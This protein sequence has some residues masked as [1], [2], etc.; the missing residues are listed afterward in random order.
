MRDPYTEAVQPIHQI[1]SLVNRAGELLSRK[2][3]AL[4]PEEIDEI[5][6]YLSRARTALDGAVSDWAL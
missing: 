5:I 4:L 1:V 2:R 6:D 3:A